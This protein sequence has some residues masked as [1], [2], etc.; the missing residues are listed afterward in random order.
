MEK[1]KIGVYVCWCGTNIAM[2]VDVKAVA[3]EMEKLPNVVLAKSYKYMCSDPGQELIIKDIKEHKLNRI[4]VAACSPRIHE[5]TFRKALE[6]A[7]LN[8][9]MLQ[10]ANIREQN[11][12]VHSDRIEATRKAKSLVAGAINRVNHHKAL[13]KREVPVNPATLIL[14]GGISG[15]SAAMELADAGKKVFLIE[16]EATLGG[17][18]AKLDL[19]FPY[20][21][22]ITD[23]LSSLIYRVDLHKYIQTFLNTEI[24]ELTGYVG[25][26]IGLIKT[27]NK[28]PRKIEFGNIIIAT[29]LKPIRPETIVNY[30][31]GK[32]REVITDL[33]FEQLLKTGSI[34][35]TYGI[36]PKN[37]AIIHC[38]GSRNDDCKTYCSRTCCMTGLKY[39]N[40][41]RSALPD[42]NINELYADMRAFGNGCEE[43][44]TETARKNI[45]FMMF[46]QRNGVPVIE[47]DAIGPGVLIK[48]NEK[49][50][51]ED[52]EVPAD[53]VILLTA[54][55]A[56][57]DAKN[58]SRLVG[59]SVDS[60]GF[61]I[62]K[63]PKLDPVATTTGGVY[64]VGSCQS[65]KDIPESVSQARAATARIL[66]TISKGFVEVEVITAEVN[67][68][69]C[70]GCQFCIQ[71]CP[72]GANGFNPRKNVSV[73]NE[74]L[75]KG[76]G[77]CGSACPS[78]AITTKHFTDEQILSQI[79][80]L[81]SEVISIEE[82]VMVKEK[83]KIEETVN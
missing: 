58:I 64:V 21:Y 42:T 29:G 46:D 10:M 55:E 67:E 11:S 78:G 54:M 73:V 83:V 25:N 53:L 37:V 34:I 76:C 12:W 69:V 39:A 8:P 62:E 33:E 13:I 80:G 27:K 20:L 75:C 3:T 5:N 77:T 57:E 32:F 35:N 51:G 2:M 24:Q 65:P 50:S 15:I 59:I 19:T 41:I 68:D 48:F 81:F 30:G 23:S 74:A 72:Y 26:F 52:I 82:K 66:A 22:S 31:Y 28:K 18:A 16:K 9:Y 6:H 14:G 44:Y 63:H 38:V 40:L 56:K 7:G 61:F 49:L 17:M 36:S 79:E 4:V 60:N 71:V 47:K 45:L 70:C 43:L 1:P